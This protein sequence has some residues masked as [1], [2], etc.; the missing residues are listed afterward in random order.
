MILLQLPPQRLSILYLSLLLSLP[1][2]RHLS[3]NTKV[4]R[5]FRNKALVP[6]VRDRRLRHQLQ[7]RSALQ[8]LLRR[9]SNYCHKSSVSFSHINNF[10]AQ[11]DLFSDEEDS[12]AAAVPDN[13][14]EI[15]NLQNQLN[16]TNKSLDHTKVER[17]NM[18]QTLAAQASQLSALQTQLSS[19]KAAFETE[20]RLLDALRERYAKQIA[21]MQ[22][23]KE[24]LIHA[25]SDLSG[26]RVEKS[27]VEGSIMR[28][29]E[30]VRELQRKMKEAGDEI[31]QAKAAI[32]KAKK[33]TKHQKGL[34]AIAKKQLATREA[35]RAKALKELEDAQ[36]EAE[37]AVKERE[38]AEEELAKEPPALSTNGAASPTTLPSV[39]PGRVDTPA[40]AA[41]QPLPASSGITTPSSLSSPGGKSNNPFERL[42]LSTGSRPASPFSAPNIDIFSAP[43]PQTGIV[44]ATSPS[45]T[46]NIPDAVE[47]L[48]TDV[49]RPASPFMHTAGA[50]AVGTQAEVP[51]AASPFMHVAEASTSTNGPSTA[52]PTT[53]ED[54]DPFG[55]DDAEDRHGSVT[56]AATTVEKGEV[57]IA[58]SEPVPNEEPFASPTSKSLQSSETK[59]E[60][61]EGKEPEAASFDNQFPPIGAAIPGGF[62]GLNEHTDLDSKLVEKEHD[63]S[64]SES[65]GES[66]FHD[67]NARLSSFSAGKEEE[68][69]EKPKPDLASN[70]TATAPSDAF[71]D[72]FGLGEKSPKI[73]S[74]PA[75]IGL[76]PSTDFFSAFTPSEAAVQPSTN[77]AVPETTAPFDLPAGQ[78]CYYLFLLLPTL[79]FRNASPDTS[80]GFERFR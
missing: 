1:I 54:D 4:L 29:K 38:T 71:D 9:V 56:S 30:D 41:A 65:D 17:Q 58:Q 8:H 66:V 63:D 15:G 39:L 72:A 67:A 73:G 76:P 60:V 28:D 59:S 13:S 34:L 75:I 2:N 24:E 52:A 31:Q 32:E 37:E 57:L 22:K 10:V 23:A 12:A 48:E 21:E 6:S 55:R 45:G 49:A 46:V 18:E 43:T 44:P 47:H 35:E 11:R 27:E 77:G 50:T 51:R 16:S 14:V 7:I 40:F 80:C 61:A 19:A 5:L 64:D 68:K 53:P 78:C 69:E 36:R 20:T 42:A 74:E 26:I 62:P 3:C 70:G 79:I 33:E 25:E